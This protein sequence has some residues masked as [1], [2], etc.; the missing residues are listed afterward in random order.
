MKKLAIHAT[1]AAAIIMLSGCATTSDTGMGGGD[2]DYPTL[3]KEAEASIKGAKSAGGEW[4]DSKKFLKK[5]AKAMKAGDMKKAIK[6][7]KKA[8]AEGEMGKTQA[9]SQKDA[10]PWLF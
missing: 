8:K 1:L 5:A 3:V 4:R 2:A 9:M 6:L 7:A 10:G